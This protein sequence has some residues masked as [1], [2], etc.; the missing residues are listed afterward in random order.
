MRYWKTKRIIHSIDDWVSF[1]SPDGDHHHD[2]G[3]DE[4]DACMQS[5]V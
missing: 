1:I 5:I 4:N 2:D 3:E